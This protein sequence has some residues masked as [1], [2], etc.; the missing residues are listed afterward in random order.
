MIVLPLQQLTTVDAPLNGL[1]QPVAVGSS[2]L[3]D[4]AFSA[5]L[6]A[7]ATPVADL[8]KSAPAQGIPSEDLPQFLVSNE[9]NPQD[10]TIAAISGLLVSPA[11][12]PDGSTSPVSNTKPD[13]ILNAL[14]PSA[15]KA[16]AIPILET[17]AISNN[18]LSSG[19]PAE[20]L[21]AK[22]GGAPAAPN[23]TASPPMQGAVQSI[24]QGTT[25]KLP[26]LPEANLNRS[27][28]GQI[29]VQDSKVAKPV[30]SNASSL[31]QNAPMPDAPVQTVELGGQG[32]SANN[33]TTNGTVPIA[34][35]EI[36]ERAGGTGNGNQPARGSLNTSINTA[37]IAVQM[38]KHKADGS[39][40]FTIRLS[41]H[42]MGTVTIQLNVSD[43]AQLTAQ[44]QV[45]K[46]ETLAL[47]QKDMAG[48]EKALKA[49]GFNTTS[50][51]ISIALKSAATVMR[52]GDVMGESL[53]DQRPGQGQQS[54]QNQ[55]GAQASQNSAS[56]NGQTTSGQNVS[57]QP[58]QSGA[59]DRGSAGN[60]LPSGD[61][62]GFQ[63]SSQ[64]RGEQSQMMSDQGFHGHPEAAEMDELD[65]EIQEMADTI[66][67]AYQAGNIH[68]GMSSQVDLSI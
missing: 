29:V 33:T 34:S 62:G 48:L 16:G 57:N 25:R 12:A 45:E 64:G 38:A 7:T 30:L 15:V 24:A 10:D 46:P 52:M 40:Q 26:E 13:A 54:A 18:G 11:P 59:A 61:T 42:S 43:N 50:N 51:D 37:D 6:A 5:W 27:P 35:A 67:T 19:N 22:N 66:T 3:G 53:A 44:M 8:P 28:A 31:A 63:Q 60:A 21:L 14:N 68:I 41:P 49:Q 23:G 9:I 36:R 65:T 47:L 1:A 2:P 17:N 20:N 39:N 4:G 55:A 58:A 32:S 56:S